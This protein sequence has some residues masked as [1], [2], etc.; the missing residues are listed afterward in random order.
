M[1]IVAITEQPLANT[2]QTA[3]RP[4]IFK[5][6]A[7]NGS[8]SIVPV[9]H[10]DIYIS[11]VYYKTISKTQYESD[12]LTNTTWLFDI[13]D[14]C[15]ERI[16][17]VLGELGG[18]TVIT[19]NDLYLE[20]ECKFRSSI[21][22][23][24]GFIQSEQLEPIQ[25]TGTTEPTSGDGLLSNMIYVIA[26]AIQHD[27][28]QDSQTHLNLYK[29]GVWPDK[30][31]PLTHRPNKYRICSGDS[32]YFP[33]FNNNSNRVDCIRINYKYKNSSSYVQ[34]QYCFDA[35]CVPLGIVGT[36]LLPDAAV[37]QPYNYSITLSGDTPIV[38]GT[39]TKPSWMVISLEENIL[40]F[41]GTPDVELSDITVSVELSNCSG[42][43]TLTFSD[44]INST[45]CVPVAIDPFT[46]PDAEAG[47][48]YDYEITLSG[49]APFALDSVTKP[50]WMNVSLVGSS[51]LLSGNPSIV[52][53][54]ETL[55]F[56]VSNCGGSNTDTGTDTLDVLEGGVRWGVT[57]NISG[58]ALN[59]EWNMHLLGP[60]GTIVTIKVDPHSNTNGGTITVDG[61]AYFQ[62]SIFPKTIDIDG[63]LIVN[64]IITGISNPGTT[65]RQMYNITG[66][67]VGTVGSPSSQEIS[68]F[69]TS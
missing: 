28:Y 29:N 2:L 1:P 44:I 52:E 56:T 19:A 8:T 36:P 34:L 37:G 24:D 67:N 12:N 66:V 6:T 47:I 65:I 64:V 14:P 39:I 25:G 17:K 54:A 4:I 30:S 69:I 15:Q 33:F 45:D 11:G 20:V 18:S 62:D 57:D 21:L 43:N 40:T 23:S 3:Y 55:T 27:E 51:I 68:K 42:G 22:N 60:A 9:V 10:C 46:L 41:S 32:D 48:E 7:N 63:D 5:V 38:L 58:S 50:S 31:F 35:E 26:I 49:D 59:G 16:K 13:Q 53:S 61:V